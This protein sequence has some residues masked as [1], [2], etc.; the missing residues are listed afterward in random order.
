V[1]L[2]PKDRLFF[3]PAPQNI[4]FIVDK[5]HSIK[6]HRFDAYR[7]GLLKS[8]SYLKEGDRFTIITVDAKIRELSPGFM[9]A[10]AANLAQAKSFLD[11]EHFSGFFEAYKPTR[12]FE[13]VQQR[14]SGHD[15]T[16]VVWLTNGAALTDIDRDSHLV[17]SLK[18]QALSPFTLYAATASDHN[19]LAML[20]LITS[21]RRGGLLHAQTHASFPRQLAKLVKKVSS[22]VA[23]DVSAVPRR[24]AAKVEL[25]TR[26]GRLPHFT[27]SEPYTI[28][29]STDSLEDFELFIQGRTGNQS[30]DITQRISFEDAKRGGTSLRKA[31]AYEE[32]HLLYESY[33]REG[34]RAYLN[35]ARDRLSPFG[36][37]LPYK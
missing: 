33:L 32:A 29:G 1:T 11:K 28:Y 5:S 6:R 22:T 31:V 8:L 2:T 13:E 21:M 15:N 17:R 23:T 30:I 26:G 9:P 19:N 4:L 36:F 7:H 14:V 34:S 12:L 24:S 25:F 27:L 18:N 3:T 20:D 16:T 10:T 35:E 37:L